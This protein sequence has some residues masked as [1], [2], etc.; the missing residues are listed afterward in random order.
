MVLH[1][2][3]LAENTT[4]TPDQDIIESL[5]EHAREVL[6]VDGVEELWLV[7]VAAEGMGHSGVSQGTE[8]AVELQRVVVELPQVFIL[9]QLQDV[10]TPGQN[11][12][13]R[14]RNEEGRDQNG[15]FSE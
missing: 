15:Q 2:K 13:D 14:G 4:N 9:R 3:I 5:S 8:G 11:V 6:V 12:K 7:Q 10:H 1:C